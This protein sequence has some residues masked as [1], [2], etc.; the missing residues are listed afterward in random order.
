MRVP[1]S[2]LE[3]FLDLDGVSPEEIAERLSLQS[4]EATVDTFGTDLDGVVFGK[5]LEVKEHP[6]RKGLYVVL[7]QAGENTKVHIVTAD[8]SLKEGDGVLVALPNSRVGD[9]CITRREFEGVVS[10]GMLLSAQDLGLEEKSEG[11]LKIEEDFGPGTDGGHILGFGEKILELDITPNRGDVLSVRGLARDLSAIL[12]LPKKKVEAEP[13]TDTGELTIEIEDEDCHRYRGVILEGVRV[14]DSPLRIRKRLWQCGIKAINNVVDI[15]NYILLQ[16]GQPL[17]AFDLDRLEGGIRVRSAKAGERIVTLDGEERILDEDVLIIADGRRPVAIAGVMGGLESAVTFETERILLESAYFD[18]RRVRKSSKKLGIQ[19]ESSYR[20]ERNVDV[21]RVDR[22]QDL[23]VSM[24]RE[25]AGGEVRAVK[26]VYPKKY[27]PRKIFLPM[28]KFIRYAGESYRN[29]EV[30]RILS[31]LE[32]PHQIKRCGIEVL[33][34]SHRSFDLSRD[35][36]VIEE[37]MRVKGYESFPSETLKL[38]SKG[39]HWRDEILE[40][41]KFLRSR[42]LREVINISYED[43]ELYDLLGLERPAVEIINPLLPT[44]RFMRSSLIPSLLRTALFNE[45]HYNYDLALF[46]VGKVFLKEGEEERLGILLKGD[47]RKFPRKAWE[48]YDMIEIIEGLARIRGRDVQLESSTI[49]FLHPHVQARVLLE[50][51]EIG[52]VGRLHPDLTARLELR[53]DPILCEIQL[54]PLL[55]DRMPRYRAL[56]KFPP[57]VRDLA[58]LVDKKVSVS[59]L[60]NEIKSQLGEKVEEVMV[61]DIYTGEK[62]GE[63][64]KSVG[65]RLVFRSKEGSL[66]SEEVG[67]LIQDLIGRLRERLGVEIR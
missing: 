9:R 7:V 66:S 23:A 30:G 3:E 44:Q 55:G 41:K 52:F 14:K 63:G 62:V 59:K 48:P 25:V 42:G 5:V 50:G 4:V 34:P 47:L 33:V 61:F 49:G 15:T 35:V 13:L 38:P 2:W 20:F 1:I 54:G 24:V 57:V 26:D 10:E 32:I 21:E 46:E 65:V 45:S 51:R 11:V 31:A 56:S 16:E 58:L 36:D 67:S 64:K 28:G 53:G 37:I 39:T 29:E 17:H 6:K 43:S 8:G 18:P 22:A 12:G 27:E 60:L 19:T 40:I